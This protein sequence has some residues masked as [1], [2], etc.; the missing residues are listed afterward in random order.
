MDV[1]SLAAAMVGAQAGRTQMAIAGKMM[2]MNADS[3]AS[4][5]QVIKAAQQNLDSLAS[6]A[7]GLGQNLDISV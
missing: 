6:A 2:K 7:S 3:A 5:I 1:S 4:I